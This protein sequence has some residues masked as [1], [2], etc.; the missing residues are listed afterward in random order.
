[1]PRGSKRIELGRADDDDAAMKSQ[2]VDDGPID[3]AD[4][5]GRLSPDEKAAV[6]MDLRPRGR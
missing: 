4:E 5:A 3:M 6:M 2:D 1:V